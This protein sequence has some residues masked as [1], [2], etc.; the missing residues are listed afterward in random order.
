[1]SHI[2]TRS[3]FSFRGGSKNPFRE[4]FIIKSLPYCV[5]CAL[6]VCLCA[7]GIGA[8][9]LTGRYYPL[10]R[11]ILGECQPNIDRKS[12]SFPSPLLELLLL[13]HHQVNALLTSS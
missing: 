10:D 12:F 5:R 3:E 1:M 2:P 9:F 11:S 13:P 8:S 7:I 4:N 6:F